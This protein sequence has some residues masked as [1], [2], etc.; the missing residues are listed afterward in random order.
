MAGRGQ[1]LQLIDPQRRNRFTAALSALLLLGA[2]ACSATEAR[3]GTTTSD[4]HSLGLGAVASPAC[5]AKQLRGLNDRTPKTRMRITASPPG[6]ANTRKSAVEIQR[7]SLLVVTIQERGTGHVATTSGC[8]V[9][10][11]SHVREGTMAIA[12][13]MTRAGY[14]ELVTMA[15]VPP[16]A[17]AGARLW[18]LHVVRQ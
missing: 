16:G 4:A 14:A 9:Q 6:Q 15:A 13:L 12:F 17:E 7:D 1:R 11:D 18:H 2:V 3:S 8:W 10:R 5:T